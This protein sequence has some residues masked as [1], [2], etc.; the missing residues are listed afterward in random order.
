MLPE[1]LGIAEKCGC[2]GIFTRGQSRT[3]REDRGLQPGETEQALSQPL[4]SL[5]MMGRTA[6]ASMMATLARPKPRPF[7]LLMTCAGHS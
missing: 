3:V 6:F 4:R 7:I 2:Q 1:N 5:S